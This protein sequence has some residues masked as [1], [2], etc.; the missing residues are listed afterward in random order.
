MVTKPYG[1]NTQ[2]FNLIHKRGAQIQE[3]GKVVRVSSRKVRDRGLWEK[4]DPEIIS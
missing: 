2:G 1:F 3:K 4:V